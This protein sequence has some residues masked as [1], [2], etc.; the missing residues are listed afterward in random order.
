[1]ATLVVYGS[2]DGYI[3][4][5]DATYSTARAGG[6]SFG[7]STTSTNVGQITGYSCYE[8]FCTFDASALDD[9]ASITAVTAEFYLDVDSSATDFTVTLAARD[10]GA[11]FEQ[12]DYVAGADLAALTTLATL[13]TSGIGATGAYKTF[14]DVA[15][16]ANLS[17][18]AAT[19][20]ILYSSRHS[21]NNTP[22]GDEYIQFEASS[23]AGT[24]QD[25][26]ITV[27]YTNDT[28]AAAGHASATGAASNA[29]PKV[30]PNAGHASAT[31]A[32]YN[33]TA[34]ASRDAVAEHI[35]V[36]AA[37][38][39]ATVVITNPNAPAGHA[40][41]T[42][43]AYDA[44]VRASV[45]GL[46]GHASATAAAHNATVN[47]GVSAGHASATAAA[48][49]ATVSIPETPPLHSIRVNWPR[50]KAY[51]ATALDLS[52][53]GFWPLGDPAGGKAYDRVGGNHGTVNGATLGSTG[54]LF[55]D[56]ATA[57]SFDGSNDYISVTDVTALDLGD[58]LSFFV[59]IKRTAT[60]AKHYIA[61]KGTG[62]W[63]LYVSAADK[64]V[65]E[66]VGTADIVASTTT[67]DTAFHLV[68]FTKN[69]STVKVY[70]DGIDVSDTVSNQTLADTTSALELGRSAAP[71]NYFAGLMQGA[72]LVDGALTATQVSQLAAAATLGQFGFSGSEIRHVVETLSIDDGGNQDYSGDKIGTLSLECDDPGLLF[73]LRNLALNPSLEWGLTDWSEVS[74]GTLAWKADAPTDCGTYCGQVTAAGSGDGASQTITGVFRS[75]VPIVAGIAVKSVSGT[76]SF[77]LTLT[78][79]T[80]TDNEDVTVTTSWARYG[81]ATITPAADRTS[82]TFTVKTNAA[83]ASVFRYDA[84]QVN[85]GS[86][87]NTYRDGPSQPWLSP[88]A[89]IH[90]KATDQTGTTR[91]LFTGEIE[92]LDPRPEEFRT[93]LVAYDALKKLAVPVD[94]R[95]VKTTAYRAR[96]ALIDRAI[97]RIEGAEQN[98]ILGQTTS[99]GWIES[100]TGSA[101]ATM[102]V[103]NAGSVSYNFTGTAVY[104]PT[105]RAG[106]YYLLSFNAR[107]S[108]GAAEL[109]VDGGEYPG[110]ISATTG[111]GG[112]A[113]LTASYQRFHLGFE[114][115]SNAAP[116]IQF[117]GT[118]ANTVQITEVVIS[119]GLLPI[120]STV[121]YGSPTGR[122]VNWYWDT[123]GV[124]AENATTLW[125]HGWNN[126]LTNP[127]A[128]TNT[129]DW[130][131]GTN[132]FITNASGT[133]IRVTAG[134]YYGGLGPVFGTAFQLDTTGAGVEGMR[135]TVSGTFYS[136]VT[137]IFTGN[138]EG[139][140][141]SG[142]YRMGIGSNGTPADYAETASTVANADS[143]WTVTWT[144]TANRTDVRVFVRDFAGVGGQ[145]T[146]TGMQVTRGAHNYARVG[147]T[148][149]D[150][151]S[152]GTAADGVT[153][154]TCTE[155]TTYAVAGSGV[156]LSS[157]LYQ[158][159]GVV[160]TLSLWIKSTSGTP[161]VVIGLGDPYGQD[162]SPESASS[163]VTLSTT[164]QR[165]VLHFTGSETS[166][167]PSGSTVI[168]W[169]A[170]SSA[171]AVTFRVCDESLTIG[172][173]VQDFTV[174]YLDLD[175]ADLDLIPTK[176][177]AGADAIGTLAELNS[178]ILARHAIVPQLTHPYWKY[179]TEARQSIASKTSD[180]TY[181]NDTG[182]GIQDFAGFE[183]DRQA[184]R[185]V[186]VVEYNNDNT[187][188]PGTGATS[189]QD[190]VIFA[191]DT[192]S[193][194]RYG[195][196]SGLTS[197]I[198][199]VAGSSWLNG[200]AGTD[201][202]AQDIADLLL[203]RFKVPRSRP[204]MV[205]EN[206]WP[207]LMLRRPGDLV[208]VTYTRAGVYGVQYLILSRNLSVTESGTK[209][210]GTFE[211]EEFVGS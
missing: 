184:I 187:I 55:E 60:G 132:A 46:A 204:V 91:A 176:L 167:T 98:L 183:M 90:V 163:T 75:G 99:L 152:I 146:V 95:L 97:A 63:G 170:A 142:S 64:L 153:N 18:T 54:I 198:H 7:S 27:T 68:G 33:A 44:T 211:L 116:Y 69:G 172:T 143:S 117:E 115:A 80:T 13:N 203:T 109:Q 135:A 10:Y 62:A 149:D 74:N 36:A 19:R 150:A 11:T 144:P 179:A 210:T 173:A 185:N 49:D 22:T 45:E 57:A 79:G 65:L 158:V 181:V 50:L 72:V 59:G 128:V 86:T 134:S 76:T 140:G 61:H 156:A 52:P 195:L 41:A 42:A 1:M 122:L 110:T 119:E 121:T 66:E 209:W 71:G 43:A 169:I 92:R 201:T 151:S 127:E 107:Y 113:S 138:I 157:P 14:T 207:E 12:G 84:L 32:A 141:G 164:W 111:S 196:V 48:Y 193:V 159:S 147:F 168:A 17:K 131:T 154:D 82:I 96:Y 188:V 35:A 155:V 8:G 120:T 124:Q 190:V 191:A 133:V 136:G 78:D 94:Q 56:A 180:E 104:W 88:G 129:T 51:D 177:L 160:Y 165:V 70:V 29:A 126:R 67:L 206:H 102:S 105:L 39:N 21:G 208:T 106:R 81:T 34:R 145:I 89:P 58:S 77:R 125:T 16:P 5:N 28:N 112:L 171:S 199:T 47:V 139:T 15:F 162:S 38:Y 4:S 175:T 25:P 174:P 178:V 100:G 23:N 189:A 205:I 2:V 148:L 101:G 6:G 194:A 87:L 85:T 123:G 24:T 118:T 30:A 202:T 31:G 83:G 186:V 3:S 197:A 37:A 166:L 40:A 137:Y 9:G 53:I 26:K 200:P 182:D 114:A 192:D 73:P 93:S 20:V 161:S 130:S 103:S 108:G